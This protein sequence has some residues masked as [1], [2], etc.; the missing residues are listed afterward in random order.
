MN[1]FTIC[2]LGFG[3]IIFF[4][5]FNQKKILETAPLPD[6]SSEMTIQSSR[7]SGPGGQNV[8]KVSSKIEVLFNVAQSKLLNEAQILK[9]T[10]KLGTKLSNEGQLRVVSQKDRSQLKNKELAIEKLYKLL[11]SC[12]IEQKPRKASKPTKSAVEKRIKE[13]KERSETKNLRR[14]PIT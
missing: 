11:G 5:K 2:G 1:D 13:K 3:Q 7:S 10:E 14:K 6:L 4:A 12:L 9:I 8:N